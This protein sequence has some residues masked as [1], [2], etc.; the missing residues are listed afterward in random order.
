MGLAAAFWSASARR[1]QRRVAQM[2]S[3][4]CVGLT[5]F[6]VDEV[7]YQ[8]LHQLILSDHVALE[9]HHLAN[10]SLVVLR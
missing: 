10:N 6:E 2:T 7:L 5:S 4:A 1:H 3:N 9:V 8:V